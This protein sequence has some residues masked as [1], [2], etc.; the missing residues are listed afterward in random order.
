MSEAEI[1]KPEAPKTASLSIND[2]KVIHRIIDVCSTRGAFKAEELTS[3]GL[4]FDRLTAFLAASE[5]PATPPE[6]GATGAP[7]A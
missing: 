5:V 3:I 7:A 2:L 6:S 4:I 1:S